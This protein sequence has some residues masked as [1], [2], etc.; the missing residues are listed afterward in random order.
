MITQPPQNQ[1]IC[2]GDN[3]TI[4]CGFTDSD[5]T[6]NWIIDNITLG[7]HEIMA[8]NR[9]YVPYVNDTSDT[10]LIMLSINASMNGTRTQCDIP[11]R[12]PIFSAVGVLTIMGKASTNSNM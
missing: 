12:T 3:V 10:V 2:E 6:P 5:I 4:T 1:T 8:N 9:L 11:T 7:R